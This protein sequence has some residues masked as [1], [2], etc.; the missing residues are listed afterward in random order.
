MAPQP[1][2]PFSTRVAE[3]RS[4]N[5]R[6]LRWSRPYRTV[7]RPERMKTGF[8]SRI[9]GSKFVTV[10]GENPDLFTSR[11]AAR[12][13]VGFKLF[14]CLCLF[15]FLVLGRRLFHKHGLTP[16]FLCLCLFLVLGRRLSPVLRGVYQDVLLAN[17]TCKFYLFWIQILLANFYLQVLLANFTCFK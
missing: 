4:P 12:S 16:L 13:K 9:S 11:A 3:P 7:W 6:W 2:T 10:C 1:L 17:F 14:L 5:C 15:L 8:Y